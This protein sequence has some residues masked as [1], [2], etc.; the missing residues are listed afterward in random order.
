MLILDREKM[1]EIGVLQEDRQDKHCNFV[2][3][4]IDY[5]EDFFDEQQR[6]K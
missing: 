3:M 6:M 5:S 1:K 2:S 4:T